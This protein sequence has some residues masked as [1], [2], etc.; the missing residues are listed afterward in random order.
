MKPIRINWFKDL[1]LY[2]TFWK[3]YKRSLVYEPT[4]LLFN[5]CSVAANY[6]FYWSS[7]FKSVGS[8]YIA[9]VCNF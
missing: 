4:L 6:C 5:K 3:L 9:A 1:F 7:V 8:K 2:S